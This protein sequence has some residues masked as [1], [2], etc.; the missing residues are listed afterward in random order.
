MQPWMYTPSAYI[1]VSHD[2]LSAESTDEPATINKGRRVPLDW[3]AGRWGVA[4]RDP[5]LFDEAGELLSF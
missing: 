2:G 1:F 4:I 3:L 5:G